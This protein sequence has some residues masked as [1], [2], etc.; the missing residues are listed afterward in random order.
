MGDGKRKSELGGRKLTILSLGYTKDLLSGVKVSGDTMS[1]L[2]FYAEHLEKYLILVL[3]LKRERLQARTIGNM[4]VTPTNGRGYLHALWRMYRL[5]A[6]ACKRG[7]V[8]VI[9]AQEAYMTG[10]VGLFLK[11][12]FGKPL[13]VCVY[14]SNP[15]DKHWRRESWFNFFVAP[16][17]RFVLRRV[18]G[19][20]VDGTLT[21]KSLEAQGLR[22]KIFF[23]PVV[24]V[25]VFEKS[26]VDEKELR[27]KLLKNG[28]FDNLFLFVGRMAKQ[29]NVPFLLSAFK[30]V[31]LNFPG[32]CLLMIGGGSHQ[33]NYEKLAEELGIEESVLWLGGVN[34]DELKAYYKA[35][36]LFVLSSYYE[37]F[38][39][40]FMEA[41]AAGLPVVTT[42][43][44]GVGDGIFHEEN[45]LVVE[46][47]DLE[48]F[49]S[50]VERVLSDVKLYD[51][52]SEGAL[53][54]AKEKY[55]DASVYSKIQ[56]EL[57]ED[58]A[59]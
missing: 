58:L 49:V 35:A 14:G 38:P 11:W 9:Q 27:E 10:L 23:K 54:L 53:K 55:S 4:E 2:S 40:V 50:E 8:D 57:W 5:G 47:G 34:Y 21:K 6:A 42:L 12:R 41:S 56:V 36:D 59:V 1:R 51:R 29:K 7:K 17:A 16:I 20:Q 39:R 32:A 3:C 46:Q 24:P 19:V 22:A 44:S 45:A 31:L 30:Q 26:N 33:S 15:F 48:G 13:N 43:V 52:L 28:R 25:G 18:D 37:G